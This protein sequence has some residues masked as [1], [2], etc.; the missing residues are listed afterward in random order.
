[1]ICNRNAPALQAVGSMLEQVLPKLAQSM[2][3]SGLPVKPPAEPLPW[4][5]FDD[6]EQYR[7]HTL[8]IECVGLS[9]PESYYSTRTNHVVVYYGATPDSQRGETD[10]RMPDSSLHLLDVPSKPANSTDPAAVASNRVLILT[11][12]LA[13]QLAFSAGLQKAGVMYPLW[14][15]EGL[16][17]YFERSALSGTGT[18]THTIRKQRLAELGRTHQ[19]LPLEDLAVLGGPSAPMPVNSAGFRPSSV[20]VYAQCWGLFGFLLEHYPQ[21]LSA[22]LMDVGQT[23]AG[24]CP[25]SSLQ[26]DFTR[27]FGPL[28]ALEQAWLQFVDGLAEPAQGS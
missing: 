2:R 26:E 9:F 15:S 7:R 11:H 10:P 21:Q 6:R 16:A 27:H 4:F 19:L 28:D 5:C 3:A 12:E 23:P 25:P 24:S 17:T 18:G 20:D 22:Y 8:A 1:V 14:V 13:H